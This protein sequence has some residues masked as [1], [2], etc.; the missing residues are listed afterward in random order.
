M[1]SASTWYG[2]VLEVYPH[3]PHALLLVFTLSALLTLHRK[4]S[5]YTKSALALVL[6]AFVSV[7]G[8]GIAL[9]VTL[10]GRRTD[11]NYYYA[12]FS[13]YV[14][15]PLL[16]VKLVMEGEEHLRDQVGIIV[17]NHQS[18]MDIIPLTLIMPRNAVI[19]AKKI[20]RFYPFL[21]IYMI[22]ARS[23]FLDRA[24][25]DKALSTFADAAKTVREEQ[26]SVFL[27][28]EGTRGH[29]KCGMLPFKKG[30]FHLAQQAQVPVIPV[31]VSSYD[32]VYSSS[33]KSFPGGTIRIKGK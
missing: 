32:N 6:V 16:N 31:V 14:I 30:A 21:G 28:P 10:F 4:S 26:V 27:F 29:L 2:Q 24:R 33:R 7:V 9:V 12:R 18:S 19:I 22:L 13:S 20:I 3:L 8:M 11:I 17:C 15:P 23:I 25:R 5:Y 1:L